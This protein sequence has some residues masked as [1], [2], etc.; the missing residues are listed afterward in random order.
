MDTAV[1]GGGGVLPETSPEHPERELKAR[2]DA[3]M[4][5]AN[6]AARS[7]TL[8]ITAGSPVV[9]PRGENLSC[10]KRRLART[11]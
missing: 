5:T 8:G 9:F 2:T 4:K 10:E 6:R 7:A 11:G 3:E 1:P